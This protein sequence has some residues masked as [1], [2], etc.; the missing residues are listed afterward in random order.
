MTEWVE[1]AIR[2]R[3]VP[4][5]EL[6]PLRVSNDSTCLDVLATAF[7]GI[8][9]TDSVV[10]DANPGRRSMQM[11]LLESA[12]KGDWVLCWWHDTD[13]PSRRAVPFQEKPLLWQVN[14]DGALEQRKT[15]EAKNGRPV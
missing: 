1:A 14:A 4:K 15:M 11:K 12:R 5:T 8:P 10:I 3:R 7:G 2:D 9:S 13:I 6:K